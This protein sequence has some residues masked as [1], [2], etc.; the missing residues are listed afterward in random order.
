MKTLYSDLRVDLRKLVVQTPPNT[1]NTPYSHGEAVGSVR[2][3]REKGLFLGFTVLGT[4]RVSGGL[5]E[6]QVYV[7]PSWMRD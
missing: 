4:A 3:T 7:H 1:P 6:W 2:R 5:G